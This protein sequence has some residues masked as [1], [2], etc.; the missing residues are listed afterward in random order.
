M[1]GLPGG[2]STHQPDCAHAALGPAPLVLASE[3]E[4]QGLACTDLDDLVSEQK[5]D[6]GML[7]RAEYPMQFELIWGHLGMRGVWPPEADYHRD[8]RGAGLRA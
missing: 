4:S 7:R 5:L 3:R 8:R 6:F 1:A 2:R